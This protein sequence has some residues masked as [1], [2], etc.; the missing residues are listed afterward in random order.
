MWAR[1]LILTGSARA[2]AP[3]KQ[4]ENRERLDRMRRAMERD[5][6]DALVL[7]LPENVLLL[8]GY[9][10]MIGSAVLVF[11]REGRA[12]LILPEY[13]AGEAGSCLWEAQ[14]VHYKFGVLDCGDPAVSVH[15]ALKSAAG[16]NWKQ[17][18]YEAGFSAL[19]PSWQSGE[20]LVP[21]ESTRDYY[22]A[23]FPDAK[24]VDV[25]ALI[26][27]ERRTKT[28][29]E[30]AKLRITGEISCIGLEAFQNA[31][32]P[33]VTGVELVALVEHAIMSKGTGYKGAQRVRGYA[34]VATGTAETA[35]AYRMHEISTMRPLQEGDAAMLELGV[36]ADGYWADRTRARVAG[37][38]TDEQARAFEVLRRAQEASTAAMRPGATGAEVD[39]A[40]RA[41]IREAGYADLFPHITGHGLGFAYHESSPMLAPGSTNVLESGMLTSVEPGIYS[42]KFGGFRIEDD[43]LVTS[44]GHEVLGPFRKSLS[45]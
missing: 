21:V 26:Q 41:L 12:T 19:A 11:P 37:Q 18:G 28:V 22:A 2:E 7:R 23:A 13:F 14:P 31:V 40:G 17:I 15:N 32:T 1:R 43:V 10:P 29:Y 25:S 20:V 42:P 30:A 27:A 6:L 39:E 8:S 38:P 33:G 16:R 24:L 36:V 9:W 5:R 34:Q 3:Q 45:A 44:S 4:M 35:I